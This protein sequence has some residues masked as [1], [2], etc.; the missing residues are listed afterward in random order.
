MRTQLLCVERQSN[1]YIV[2][3]N[4][5]SEDIYV[6]KVTKPTYGL[7]FAIWHVN[8]DIMPI[9]DA[10]K[11]LKQSMIV[12]AVDNLKNSEC[13]LDDLHKLTLGD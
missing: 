2:T 4:P 10:F 13:L 12:L 9:E 11:T 5:V 1:K 8:I 3:I 7:G 6:D